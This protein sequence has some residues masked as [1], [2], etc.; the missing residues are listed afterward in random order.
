MKLTLG[1]IAIIIFA[2]WRAAYT[3]TV[4]PEPSCSVPQCLTEISAAI[5]RGEVGRVE[6]LRVSPDLET[7][8]RITPYTLEQIYETKLVIRNIAETSLRDKLK[9]ALNQTSASPR[10][11]IGDLRWAIIFFSQKEVRLGAFYF[12]RWGRYGAINDKGA[13]FDGSLFRWLETTSSRS[14]DN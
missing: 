4:S 9:K 10:D 7:R 11:Q 12:E 14:P 5:D 3:Q 8:T 1:L 13:A 2:P 6:I